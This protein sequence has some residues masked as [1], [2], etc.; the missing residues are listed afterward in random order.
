MGLSGADMA[1]RETIANAYETAFEAV[2]NAPSMEEA[3]VAVRDIYRIDNATYHLAQV[4]GSDVDGP[5]VK[6]TYPAEWL[7]RYL[8]KGYIRVDP[9][10]REG[11][12]RTLPFDW[13]ELTLTNDAAELFQD[14]MAHGLG[15]NGYSVPVVDK[16][17]RKALFSVNH[18][19]EPEEWSTFIG[20]H[21]IGFA[22]LAQKLH[23]KAIF[24]I[25]GEFDPIPRLGPRELE[26]L[27]WTAQGKTAK[28]IARLLNL[29]EF[30][31]KD[32]LKV[33]RLKLDCSN[34]AQAVAKA[35]NLRIIHP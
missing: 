12:S 15:G 18:L 29:N 20:E 24:E 21:G 25:H 34:V 17:A 32:Y 4:P 9:V 10:V 31:V 28:E 11:F 14:F 3:I 35:V 7:T 26:C 2:E 5:Y 8:L 1:V 22:E 23:R 13:S 30:T 19:C 27:T 16:L 33:A 6:S